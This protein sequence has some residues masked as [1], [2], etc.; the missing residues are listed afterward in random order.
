VEER[1]DLA[2]RMT[3][4]LEPNLIARPLG[5][6]H[7]VICATPDYLARHGMP[8][9]VEDLALHNCLTHSYVGRSLWQFDP[10]KKKARAGKGAAAAKMKT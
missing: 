8:R 2:I 5:V 3:N 4:R 7:S 6:C 9:K 1:I 10:K